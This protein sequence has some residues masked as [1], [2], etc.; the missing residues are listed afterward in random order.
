MH[1]VLNEV[2]RVATYDGLH[3]PYV[4]HYCTVY[5]VLNRVPF[6]EKTRCPTV[7]CMPYGTAL[8]CGRCRTQSS[9]I[10]RN[11]GWPTVRY[12]TYW[13]KN[14]SQQDAMGYCCTVH[15]VPNQMPRS[16]KYDDLQ[17]G[18]CRTVHVPYGGCRTVR[19]TPYLNQVLRAAKYDGLLYGAHRT[20]RHYCTAHTARNQAPWAAKCHGLP[21][22]RYMP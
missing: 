3:A 2:P 18:G 12:M 6:A 4:R 19:C 10:S 8:L 5:A 17:Y 7:R 14:P 15:A 1:A 11:T 9:E 16:A 21:H 13:I 20:I 22:G